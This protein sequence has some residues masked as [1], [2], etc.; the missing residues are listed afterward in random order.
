[1]N[2][3]LVLYNS[4]TPAAEMMAKA[5][6]EELEA[7]MDAWTTW[8]Q[9]NGDSIIDLGTPLGPSMHVETGSVT[10]GSIQATGYSILRAE[11]LEEATKT[12]EDHPHLH[13][14]DGTIDVLEMLP[15]PGV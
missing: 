5:T 13:T 1:M 10:S 2:R 11:S 7:G 14:P 9:T 12:L 15:M 3:Y 8:A 4:P 6:P